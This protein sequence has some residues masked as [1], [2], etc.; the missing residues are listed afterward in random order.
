[1][2]LPSLQKRQPFIIALI[3]VGIVVA[4][5]SALE[6]KIPAIAEFCGMLGDGCHNTHQY[7][8]FG[9]PLAPWGMLYYG[10]MGML[11]LHRRGWVFWGAVAGLGFELALLRIMVEN[12]FICVFCALNFLVVCFIWL[13]EFDR[14]RLWETAAV[15]LMTFTLAGFLITDGRSEKL[16]N[17]TD[18]LALVDGNAIWAEDIERPLSAP[19]HRQEQKIY[20]LKNALL[21]N[22]INDRLLEVDAEKRGISVDALLQ[23]IRSKIPPLAPH[24]VDHYYETGLY[25]SLGDWAGTEDEVKAHIRE[26]LHERDTAPLVLDYFKVLRERYPVEIYLKPPPLPSTQVR[27]DDA[28]SIGPTDAPVTV[29]ELSD[30]L[31]PSCRKSHGNV[32]AIKNKYAGQIRW[33]F[34]D[35]PLKRHPGARELALAARFAEI[36][37]QFWAFQDKLFSAE[38]LDFEQAVALAESLGMDGEQLRRFVADPAQVA[39]LEQDI[40]EARAAGISATPTFI[41]N[42]KMRSGAPS[43]DEFTELIDQA[44]AEADRAHGIESSSGD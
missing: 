36:Q 44:L 31:C 19:L 6:A 14:N 11:C 12:E 13:L 23:Q 3:L 29:V 40:D 5:L 21:Q 38:Q 39:A 25:R 30:Y 1:M 33:V 17:E 24:V 34:K 42:G 22:R 20:E 9:L 7:R 2:E 32:Q 41:I 35:Y 28:P 16:T 8:L 43:I 4:S 10:V 18:I 27:I 37:G 15:S 26:A